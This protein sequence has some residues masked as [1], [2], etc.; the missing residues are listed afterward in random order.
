VRKLSEAEATACEL[1]EGDTTLG[2]L[3]HEEANTLRRIL[4]LLLPTRAN[5]SAVDLI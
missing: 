2:T 1:M 5:P 4:S 3:Q